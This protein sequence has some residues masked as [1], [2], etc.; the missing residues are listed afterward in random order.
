MAHNALERAPF[1]KFK[2]IS[3]LCDALR[4]QDTATPRAFRTVGRSG[5]F[6]A[7]ERRKG[8]VWCITYG[9][10]EGVLLGYPCMRNGTAVITHTT[11]LPCLLL[12]EVRCGAPDT[13]PSPSQRINGV[14]PERERQQAHVSHNWQSQSC[15]PGKTLYC[16]CCACCWK[17]LREYTS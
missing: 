15:R 17:S 11:H 16:S 3:D 4:N 14:H 8:L 1:M 7:G 10:E 6:L 9:T 13:I 2:A 5:T 12:A